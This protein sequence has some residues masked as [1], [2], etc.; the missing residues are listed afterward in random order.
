MS[1]SVAYTREDFLRLDAE[2]QLAAYRDRFDLPANTIY[3]DGNSLG[4]MPAHVPERFERILKKEWAHGLIRSWNDADWYPAPQRAGAKIAKLIDAKNNEVIVADSTSI[5]LF[6]VLVAALRINKD[7]KVILGERG[8]FPTDVYI[9]SGVAELTGSEVRCVDPEEVLDALNEDVAV[10]S[11]T[12]VNYKSGRRYDMAKITKR[13]HEVGA[14]VVWDLCHSV[15]AMPVELNAAQVD[16]AVGCTYKYLNGG[17]GSPAFVFVAERHFANVDQPLTGWHGHA[18]PFDFDH[19]YRPHPTIDRM[20]VGTAPQLGILGLEASLEVFDN[21][22]M[23]LVRAKSKALGDLFV[24]LFDQHLQG[25]GVELRSPR[26][27]EERG[28]QISLSHEQAYAVMQAMIDRGIIGDFRAPD[29][30]RFGF[31]PL[32][33]RYVDIW[34]CIVSLRE[35]L[36]QRIWDR[37]EFLAR[38]SVT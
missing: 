3:L 9:A 25:L 38:K 36:E 11:L 27:G 17:P 14:L 6:K 31:A 33:I 20:L 29:I 8:N 10:L 16:F 37:P 28:S 2:D 4:A 30:L 12:H 23:N 35:I 26:E 24:A 21:I 19:D 18:K 15:G 13:A 22:D 7:R 34:D 5:N 32:Y 1:G